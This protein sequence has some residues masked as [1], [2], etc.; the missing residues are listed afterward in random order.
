MCHSLSLLFHLLWSSLPSSLCLNM[1]LFHSSF[2]LINKPLC[3]YIS[4]FLYSFLCP[5]TLRLQQC[6]CYENQSGRD[7]MGTPVFENVAS[8]WLYAQAH[9]CCFLRHFCVLF[10]QD[11]P[12]CSF[13]WMNQW[14]FLVISSKLIS[15]WEFLFLKFSHYFANLQSWLFFVFVVISPLF[16][17]PL[18]YWIQHSDSVF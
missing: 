15:W 9:D 4:H 3:V 13:S 8:P 14:T 7:G 17:F 2:W 18:K 10:F 5:W 6:P 12:C 16:L 1:A 11:P